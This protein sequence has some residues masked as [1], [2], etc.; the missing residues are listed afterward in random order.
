M[1]RII[2][3]SRLIGSQTVIL[4]VWEPSTYTGPH[5]TVGTLGLGR[6]C[7]GRLD[8]RRSA[9]VDAMVPGSPERRAAA[10]AHS[11]RLAEESVALIH[12]TLGRVGKVVAPW[13]GEV[14][15][16]ADELDAFGWASLL[17]AP[18]EVPA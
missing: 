9:E 3:A 4:S 5:A 18:V 7:Y 1:D 12:A 15:T 14:H 17:D 13:N 16:T 8:S 6:G 10:K 2:K 11:V